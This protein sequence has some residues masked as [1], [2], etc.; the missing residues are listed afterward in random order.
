MCALDPLHV[1]A[2][3]DVHSALTG[4]LLKALGKSGDALLTSPVSSASTP[5]TTCCSSSKDEVSGWH[6][7]MEYF[8]CYQVL[9]FWVG[10]PSAEMEE[11]DQT[12]LYGVSLGQGSSLWA[13]QD[14]PILD[15]MQ[16]QSEGKVK[17][18]YL[19]SLWII[20][21]HVRDRDSDI[22][23]FTY[24]QP[25]KRTLTLL[26]TLSCSAV[27]TSRPYLKQSVG[28]FSL[29]PKALSRT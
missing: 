10:F 8:L 3:W 6:V 26:C 7:G 24:S 16:P 13:F 1:S 2:R 18:T 23:L 5:G 22:S 28:C 19:F 11:V 4:H 15:Q 14:A 20:S 9:M 12:S 21:F 29:L 17:G 25:S 27:P